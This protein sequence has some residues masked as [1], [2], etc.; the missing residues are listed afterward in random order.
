MSANETKVATEE[1]K[2]AT[3]ELYK[4]IDQPSAELTEAM[5]DSIG[6][7]PKV[8]SHSEASKRFL[9]V[10]NLAW[11]EGSLYD[12]KKEAGYIKAAE[13]KIGKAAANRLK[14]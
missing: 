7:N 12:E 11:Q 3:E 10:A 8:L 9:K 4:N 5:G 2:V 6:K 13:D 1:L 14:R